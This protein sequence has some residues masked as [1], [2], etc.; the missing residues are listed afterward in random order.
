MDRFNCFTFSVRSL[1][2]TTHWKGDIFVQKY[3]DQTLDVVESPMAAALWA[4]K[5]VFFFKTKSLP[6]CWLLLL[7][8][9][10]RAICDQKAMRYHRHFC[11]NSVCTCFPSLAL[12]NHF[13]L[14]FC[15][16][17]WNLNVTVSI[18]CVVYLWDT[19]HNRFFSA[20]AI[21]SYVSYARLRPL[22]GGGGA[23]VA[24]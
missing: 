7:L 12:I 24:R 14:N 13:C 22:A 11:Q 1:E 8:W 9:N 23:T 19:V 17:K 3:D 6:G 5:N 10:K 20:A 16:G 4:N 15:L 2:H 21:S 18:G